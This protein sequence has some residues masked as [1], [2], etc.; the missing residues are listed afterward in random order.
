MVLWALCESVGYGGWKTMYNCKWGVNVNNSLIIVFYIYL[1]LLSSSCFPH[2]IRGSGG[3]ITES[4]VLFRSEFVVWQNRRVSSQAKMI[5]VSKVCWEIEG[6]PAAGRGQQRGGPSGLPVKLLC[7]MFQSPIPFK[8]YRVQFWVLL[9]FS[10]VFLRT[11]HSQWAA[12][13]YSWT[14]QFYF[15]PR[16]QPWLPRPFL[17]PHHWIKQVKILTFM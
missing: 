4:K 7:L 1:H 16:A 14:S 8:P 9:F 13:C 5:S 10:E 12:S 11:G 2:F 3:Y 17:S 15:P 6:P